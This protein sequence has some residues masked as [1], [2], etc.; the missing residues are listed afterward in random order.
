[1]MVLAEGELSR[2]RGGA[3]YGRGEIRN[4]R[5]GKELAAKQAINTS[6]ARDVLLKDM[7]SKDVEGG[8]RRGRGRRWEEAGVYGASAGMWSAHLQKH[9]AVQLLWK[10]WKLSNKHR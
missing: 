8:G 4:N 10:P 7:R 5:Q 9:R 3:L 2:C 6:E 1:M